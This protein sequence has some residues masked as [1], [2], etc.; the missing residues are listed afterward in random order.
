MLTG[1]THNIREVG[2]PFLIVSPLYPAAL[3]PQYSGS[4]LDP[5]YLV[6]RP[7]TRYDT[8]YA[9]DTNVDARVLAEDEATKGTVTNSELNNYLLFFRTKLNITAPVLLLIG[10]KDAVFCSLA[11]GD[12]GAPCDDKAALIASERPWFG[13]DVPSVSAHIVEGAGHALNALRSS[14]DTLGFAQA[15]LIRGLGRPPTAGRT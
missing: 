2:T 15:W 6:N 9:P 7:G 4:G 5:G 1:A 10:G 3:D 14:N 13:P 8:F 12:L 11:P